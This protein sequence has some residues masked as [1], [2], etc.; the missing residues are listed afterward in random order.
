MA[1]FL[2]SCHADK[3]ADLFERREA[4][5]CGFA[6]GLIY[7]LAASSAKVFARVAE[8]E[9]VVMGRQRQRANLV[10]SAGVRIGEIA[11]SPVKGLGLL[12]PSKSN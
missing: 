4:S 2:E 7:Q 1:P 11:Y 5:A 8:G 6:R 9:R 10:R 12:Y 3:P